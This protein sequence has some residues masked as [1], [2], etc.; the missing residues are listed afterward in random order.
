VRLSPRLRWA[1]LTSAVAPRSWNVGFTFDAAERACTSPT[2]A[3]NC[4]PR[5][6]ATVDALVGLLF[7]CGEQLSS[8]PVTTLA[9][10]APPAAGWTWV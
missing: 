7:W 6:M 10:C 9:D 2:P 3:D 8:A 5:H 1:A 4:Y